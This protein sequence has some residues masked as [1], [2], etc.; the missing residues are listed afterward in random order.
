MFVN[1]EDF[2]TEFAF[3]EKIKNL[4]IFFMKNKKK[5]NEL[6]SNKVDGSYFCEAKIIPSLD[7]TPTAAPALL[8]AST[9]Y[10]TYNNLPKKNKNKKINIFFCI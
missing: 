4:L 6:Y 1:T 5:I 7:N 8:I 2:F 3:I 9:A 10:S